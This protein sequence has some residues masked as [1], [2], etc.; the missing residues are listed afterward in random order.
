MPTCH[1]CHVMERESFEDEEVAAILNEHY[2]SIKVDREERPDVDQIYMTVC[3]AMTGHGGWPLTIIMTPDKEPFFAGTYFPK[4]SKYGRPGLVDILNQIHSKWLEDRDRVVRTGKQITQAI[5]EHRIKTKGN[6]ELTE[7]TLQE[8]YSQYVSTFDGEYGGFGSAPKFPSPHNLAFLL[9][10]W[11]LT[12]EER[13][14][15]MVEKTLDAMRRGGIYDHIGFGFARYSVDREWLVPHFEKMLYDN[16][17]LALIYLDAYQATKKEE[18]AETAR[19]IF[20]YVLRDMTHPEGGFYSAEDADSEG[21]EGKFYVWRPEEIR[22][23][24]GEEDGTRF[25]RIYDITEHGNFE[26]NT[27]IPNLVRKSLDQAAREEGMELDELKPFIEKCRE[28]LFTARETRVHPHK[29]D[30]ILTAWNG[31]MIAALARGTV[32]LGDTIYVA[33]AERALRF[34]QNRLQREDGRLLARYR[35]EEAAFLGYLDDYAFLIWGLLELYEATFNTDY[36]S[37]ALELQEKQVALFWD[38]EEGGFYFYG[39]DGEALLFRPKE[40]YDGAIPSGNSVAALNLL[41]LARLTGKEDIA[42]LADE[43]IAAFAGEVALYPQA[44]AHFMMAAQFLFGPVKEII[45]AAPN[46]EAAQEIV[47]EVQT[48]FMPNA[49]VSVITDETRE[50]L[51]L[52]APVL[53]DKTTQDGK[54]TV[55][56]CENFACQKPVTSL[57]ELKRQLK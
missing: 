33:A 23:I 57:E 36:L 5:Q 51:L 41:R 16:A 24:L 28:K 12:G 18:Y 42:R 40:L 55:Y 13:A 19:Q 25:C 46:R 6:G 14:L 38:N 3:Q 11:K 32:V 27:S 15:A 7:Q 53:T 30:K 39:S 9:R 10:H 29:D 56:I 49:V 22:Q 1:W 45:V 54:A 8:A 34:I 21:E 50:K 44:H 20:T 17:L 31:L 48:R 4:Q 26:H 47:Q 37:Y 2:V 43:Q 52:L 35:D